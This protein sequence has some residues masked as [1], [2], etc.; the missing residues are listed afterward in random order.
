MSE[1]K[2]FS[3]PSIPTMEQLKRD[4]M[5]LEINPEYDSMGRIVRKKNLSGVERTMAKSVMSKDN[6]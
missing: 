1:K 2:V 6:E 5:I 4:L 3:M